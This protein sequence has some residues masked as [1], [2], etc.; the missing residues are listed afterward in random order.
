MPTG[1]DS[2]RKRAL[3]A[4]WTAV[5]KSEPVLMCRFMSDE[6]GY[7]VSADSLRRVAEA[8]LARGIEVPE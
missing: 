8:L 4:A 1:I 3:E 2:E 7:W 6:L 5:A